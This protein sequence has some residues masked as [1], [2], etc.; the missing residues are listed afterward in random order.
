MTI[1][2]MGLTVTKTG[3][4]TSYPARLTVCSEAAMV[5][6]FVTTIAIIL[7]TI[8]AKP[9]TIILNPVTIAMKLLSEASPATDYR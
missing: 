9:A 6:G 8:V 7:M 2:A 4:L 5:T 1:T 3:W